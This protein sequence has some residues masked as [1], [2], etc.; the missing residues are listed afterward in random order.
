MISG[1][2]KNV[3]VVDMLPHAL[4]FVFL[5]ELC[6]NGSAQYGLTPHRMTLNFQQHLDF[7]LPEP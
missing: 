1:V 2:C 7:D 5:V 3:D 4:P 6:M